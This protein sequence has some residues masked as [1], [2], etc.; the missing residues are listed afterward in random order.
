MFLPCNIVQ[1][2]VRAHLNTVQS[3]QAELSQFWYVWICLGTGSTENFKQMLLG[4]MSYWN[5]KYLPKQ[6][7]TEGWEN[8]QKNHDNLVQAGRDDPRLERLRILF[9][10][11]KKHTGNLPHTSKGFNTWESFKYWDANEELKIG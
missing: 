2:A 10:H 8:N 9:H 3:Q 7:A 4:K 5:C 1:Y 11:E 6:T